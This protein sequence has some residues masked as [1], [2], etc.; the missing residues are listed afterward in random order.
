MTVKEFFDREA[1]T[2]KERGLSLI[3]IGREDCLVGPRRSTFDMKVETLK[4]LN[5]VLQGTNLKLECHKGC[6]RLHDG[7]NEVFLTGG[8]VLHDA[9]TSFNTASEGIAF[10]YV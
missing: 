8:E 10:S 5:L 4:G 7:S 6:Y 9:I 3:R 1:A 2:L